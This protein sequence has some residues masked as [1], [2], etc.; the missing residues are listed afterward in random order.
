MIT[1]YEYNEC[2]AATLHYHIMVT[3][4]ST[5]SSFLVV[6]GKSEQQYILFHFQAA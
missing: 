3:V 5:S 1:L 6:S 2:S 4:T